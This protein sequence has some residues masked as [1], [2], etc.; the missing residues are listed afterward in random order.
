MVRKAIES[1]YSGVCS[2]VEYVKVVDAVTKKTKLTESTV[3]TNQPCRLSFKNIKSADQTEAGAA[4]SQSVK[5]FIAPEIQIKPGSKITVLQ[6][7]MTTVYKNSG[8]V[9]VYNFHQEV[10]LVI[11]EEWG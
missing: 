1:L 7:G 5:L 8:P 9:V 2:I 4:L 11:F 3:L 6:N 10:P